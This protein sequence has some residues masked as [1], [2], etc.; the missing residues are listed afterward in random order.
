MDTC[1]FIYSVDIDSGIVP[2]PDVE[3]EEP[4]PRAYALIRP[5]IFRY[6]PNGIMLAV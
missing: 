4:S 6:I 3:K 1:S 5:E 2:V